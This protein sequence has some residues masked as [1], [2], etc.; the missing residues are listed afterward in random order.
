MKQESLGKAS[1]LGVGPC[2]AATHTP[3]ETP[4]LRCGPLGSPPQLSDL[5]SLVLK[6]R[7]VT[8]HRLQSQPSLAMGGNPQGSFALVGV[9]Q[10][11]KASKP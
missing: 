9:Y 8:I 1:R 6:T 5:E 7:F 11:R 2:R 10:Q 4:G 3:V